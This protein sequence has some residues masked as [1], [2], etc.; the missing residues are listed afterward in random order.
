VPVL[1]RRRTAFIGIPKPRLSG[2]LLPSSYVRS[3]MATILLPPEFKEL[4][5]ALSLTEVEYLIVGQ[6]Q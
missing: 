4:L 5:S 1:F 6:L 2:S 3:L